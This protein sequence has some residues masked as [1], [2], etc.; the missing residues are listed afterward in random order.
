MRHAAGLAMLLGGIWAAVV[1]VTV[2]AIAELGLPA[3]VQTFVGDL[4]HPW[5]AQFY[6]DL[7]AH[8]IMFA[9][10]IVWRERS[11]AVGVAFA[12]LTMLTGALFTLPYVI[13]AG[14]AARGDPRALLLG[15]GAAGPRPPKPQ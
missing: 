2:W 5:R 3:A 10:W 15:A 6:A 13:V 11:R 8:L 9:A 4:R 1:A 7:E 12:V 14:I